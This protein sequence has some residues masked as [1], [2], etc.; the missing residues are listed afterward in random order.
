MRNKLQVF[1]KAVASKKYIT[2]AMA[3]FEKR[4]NDSFFIVVSD[5][6]RWCKTNLAGKDAVISQSNEAIVDLAI[7]TLPG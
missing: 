7:M 5:A 6:K 1:G 2:T 3:Y 4:Y